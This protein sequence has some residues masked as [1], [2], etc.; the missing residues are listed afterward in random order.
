MVRNTCSLYIVPSLL[1]LSHQTHTH[2]T[3]RSKNA[4]FKGFEGSLAQLVSDENLLESQPTV[5]AT[6]LIGDTDGEM[7]WSKFKRSIQY[8]MFEHPESIDMME[9]SETKTHVSDWP[10]RI[11][12][13]GCSGDNNSL[14]ILLGVTDLKIDMLPKLSEGSK[15]LTLTMRSPNASEMAEL[16][17]FEGDTSKIPIGQRRTLY[18]S[19]LVVKISVFDPYTISQKIMGALTQ[20]ARTR[21]QSR[22][23]M[24]AQS[25]GTLFVNYSKFI[26]TVYH[27]EFEISQNTIVTHFYISRR[28]KC[29]CNNT[30]E[31]S[32]KDQGVG[33]DSSKTVGT[34]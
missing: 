34:N 3:I 13:Q 16:H 1:S 21:R 2:K 25:P 27:N 6:G 7:L 32:T 19:E 23:K 17:E 26:R 4:Q 20:R 31:S 33:D 29:R 5:N 15:E 14:P 22:E 30:E 24:K 12:L 28:Y 8:L 11:Y 10:K 18:G 9:S